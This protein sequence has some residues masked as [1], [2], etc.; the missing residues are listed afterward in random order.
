MKYISTTLSLI[1]TFIFFIQNSAL[2]TGAVPSAF[3]QQQLE[4]VVERYNSISNSKKIEEFQKQM[5]S[6]P[7][8]DQDFIKNAGDI[9]KFIFPTIKMVKGDI[10]FTH[11]KR[12]FVFKP[13]SPT[14]VS[15][16]GQDIDFSPGK[17]EM[18]AD[19]IEKIMNQQKFSVLDLVISPAH[20]FSPREISDFKNVGGAIA[21]GIAGAI[22]FFYLIGLSIEFLTSDINKYELRQ[23]CNLLVKR[24]DQ[25]F[26]SAVATQKPIDNDIL[27]LRTK[28]A[29]TRMN[30]TN[31]YDCK[32][33][34]EVCTETK[35]CLDELSAEI[36]K[37]DPDAV[38]NQERGSV[39]DVSPSSPDSKGSSS[40]EAIGQ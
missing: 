17:F 11:G 15:F 19:Q 9:T 10:T 16:E 21:L 14:V 36:N 20:A 40:S 4:K 37:Y 18:A 38:S 31:S 1:F 35:K 34:A 12:D 32:K 24:Y 25:L 3:T 27:L 8:A 6:R 28:I 22:T 5:E 13:K 23:N 7:K 39:K 30:L 26:Q 33:Y 29:T 2:A